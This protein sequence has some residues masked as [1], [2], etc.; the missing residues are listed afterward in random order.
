[1]HEEDTQALTEP[2]VAP[3][4]RKKFTLAEQDLPTTAYNI[5]YDTLCS[6]CEAVLHVY[7][8][9]L[10]TAMCCGNC[11]HLSYTCTVLQLHSVTL[12]CSYLVVLY[13]PHHYSAHVS[14]MIQ[15]SQKMSFL[16]EA[17]WQ[18]IIRTF[19]RFRDTKH[20]RITSGNSS[21]Y[22]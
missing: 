7:C 8:I 1:M 15:L 16:A 19:M 5:E 14:T 22:M 18:S 2:I 3:I 11:M 9:A 10:K 21:M 20:V 6:P 4:K 17:I 12:F 13:Q